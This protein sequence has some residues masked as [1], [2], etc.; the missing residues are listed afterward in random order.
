V[1]WLEV[2][3]DQFLDQPHR[4]HPDHPIS[5]HPSS[6]IDHA[7]E[8]P[9][10]TSAAAVERTIVDSAGDLLADVRLFDV[11]RGAG[12]PDGHRSLA[13]RLRLQAHDRTLTDADAAE[14]RSAVVAAVAERHGAV[15]RG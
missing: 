12:L 4:D 3:L 14:V 8:V 6:D 2:D 10:S 1:G 5:R 9:E 7:F 11:Y 13:Y 15:L